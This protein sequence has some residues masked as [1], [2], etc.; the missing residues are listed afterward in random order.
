MLTNI[1]YDL[2]DLLPDNDP[3]RVA[4]HNEVH[5]RPNPRIRLPALIVYVVVINDGVTREKEC[6]HLRQLPGQQALMLEQLENNFLR[7]RLPGLHAE[8]GAT[9]RIHA[10]FAG[11]TFTGNCPVR[12][13]RSRIAV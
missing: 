8:M 7:L 10:L 3:Q 12:C 1:P 2:T 9:L 11:A 5:A 13:N 6:A 4:L